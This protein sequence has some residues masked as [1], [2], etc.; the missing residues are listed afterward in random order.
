MSDGT[1]AVFAGSQNEATA[2]RAREI[3]G[4]GSADVLTFSRQ[5]NDYTFPFAAKDVGALYSPL[6]RGRFDAIV[7]EQSCELFPGNTTIDW[8]AHMINSLVL[9]GRIFLSLLE[10][11]QGA[12]LGRVDPSVSLT[13]LGMTPSMEGAWVVATKPSGWEAPRVNSV[14]GAYLQGRGDFVMNAFLGDAVRGTAPS[15]L[16]WFMGGNT[17]VNPDAPLDLAR[18]DR[19]DLIRV[20]ERCRAGEIQQGEVEEG[21][22][23]RA[24][25]AVGSKESAGRLAAHMRSWQNYMMYGTAYKAASIASVL[26]REFGDQPIK[27]LEHGGYAGALSMQLLADLPSVQEAWCCEID[28]QVLPNTQLLLERLPRVI[29]ERFRFSLTSVEEHVYQSDF[30]VV[31]FVHMLLYVRRDQ[32]PGVLD[33][34]RAALRPGGV[35]LFLENTRPPTTAGGADD[36]LIF[37][38]DELDEYLSAI[39]RV[40]YAALKSGAGLSPEEAA[41]KQV[42]RMV[43]PRPYS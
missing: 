17:L 13:S 31:A 42:M 36:A 1:I 29:S 32:L 2:L 19:K 5:S 25:D 16:G 18:Y 4:L 33:Q 28:P 11:D 39:G 40:K 21:I 10:P 6:P 30:D 3:T 7:V 34:A 41:G 26:R 15:R 22:V 20:V 23:R 24:V 9:G 12:K 43:Q 14:L 38:P 35:L 37:S 8:L 27:F